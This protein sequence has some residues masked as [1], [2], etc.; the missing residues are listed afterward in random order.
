VSFLHSIINVSL[1][2]LLYGVFF[3]S[4]FTFYWPVYFRAYFFSTD[5]QVA[6]QKAT[7]NYVRMFFFA[8]RLV[9]PGL[10]LQGYGKNE[11][12]VPQSSIIVCNHISFLDPLLIIATVGRTT[13][14]VNSKYFQTPLFGWI[15][16]TC[17]YVSASIA[18]TDELWFDRI[19]RQLETTLSGGGNVFIFPEGTRSKSGALGPF[20]KG[21]FF[22]AQKLGAPIELFYITATNRIFPPRRRLLNLKVTVNVS[23]RSIGT[24]SASDIRRMDVNQIR[25]HVRRRYLEEEARWQPTQTA[26]IDSKATMR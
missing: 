3:G 2:L 22:F 8:L 11:L 23:I 15:L 18:S 12:T 1:N 13:T 26:N 20:K 25:D 7:Q 24:L 21:A 14:L 4:F 6:F 17:G 16:K 5:R 9:M 19:Y 10:T